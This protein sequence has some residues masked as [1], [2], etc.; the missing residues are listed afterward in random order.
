MFHILDGLPVL[1]DVA[2]MS[3]KPTST[4]AVPTM[5]AEV[6]RAAFPQGNPY[7][8][9]R[10]ELGLIFND[11][12]FADLFPT[13]G[14]PGLPP[15]RL[16]LV[17]VL[18]FRENLSARQAAD[19]VRARIDW[20]YL[21]GLELTDAGFDFSVLSE[22][23]TRLVEAE[24]S[25]RLLNPLLQVCQV[26]GL[27]QARGRQRTDA[28]HVLT[29]VRALNRLELVA[30]TLRA[31]LNVIAT[32]EPVW[33]KGHVPDEWYKRY[34][35]RIEYRRRPSS[36]AERQEKA[37]Q[38]G[39]DGTLLLDWLAMPETPAA[40]KE[41]PEVDIL[42]AV[43]QRHYQR[44]QTNDDNPDKEN[45]CWRVNQELAKD[46][47][48]IKTPYDVE[49][50]YRNKNGLTW[51]GY[52][53]HLSETC[54]AETPHL[55]TQVMTTPANV[56]D[57]KCTAAIQQALVDQAIPPAIH[58]ADASYIAGDLLVKSQSQHK[59]TL[60]GPVRDSARWQHHVEGLT[61]WTSSHLTGTIKQPIAHKGKPRPS[62]IHLTKTMVMLIFVWCLTRRTVRPVQN[63]HGVPVRKTPHV[64]VRFNCNHNRNKKRSIVCGP[65]SI[66]TKASSFT[67]NVLGLK[68]H[69]PKVFAVAGYDKAAMSV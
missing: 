64:L 63:G 53:V 69:L 7:L 65:I 50:R 67:T 47:D 46:Q 23:R 68:A 28:T 32:L 45:L 35:R 3:L 58:L 18:Q 2:V 25:D 39:E 21:L 20:K 57:A 10:D 56:G 27:L 11:T 37:Q 52:N 14:Q 66:V 6:A 1:G 48:T 4:L 24:A 59:I 43:W 17:T 9:L 30:K 13:R 60:V 54:D 29:A 15:W 44:H 31:T 5:T 33:L 42:K 22:F 49:A 38:I 51:L 26:Q 41:L 8:C 34:G 55:V 61:H 12:D 62:G 16:A 40:L 36:E 19:A